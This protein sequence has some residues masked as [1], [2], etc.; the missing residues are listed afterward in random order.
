MRSWFRINFLFICSFSIILFSCERPKP[1]FNEWYQEKEGNLVVSGSSFTETA[2]FYSTDLMIDTIYRSMQGPFEIKPIAIDPNSEELLWITGYESKVL[3]A[4]SNVTLGPAF[5]CHNNLDY[6][7]AEQLPWQL[8]TSGANHRI[9]TLSQGQS[10]IQFPEGFG[11]PIPANQSLNMVSQVLNHHRPELFI[12]TKHQ[13]ELKYLRESEIDGEMKALYQQ[14][15][16][17]TKQL[18]GAEG[19]HG[20][21]LSCLPYHDHEDSPKEADVDHDCSIEYSREADYNPYQDKYGRKFTGHWVIPYGPDTLRTNVSKMMDLD[22]S[23]RIHLISVHLHPY[24]EA[25]ELWDLSSN[26]LI[27]EASFQKDS[28][29][30]GFKEIDYFSSK[31]GIPVYADHQYELV[32]AYDCTDSLNEHTAMAVMYLYLSE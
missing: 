32:S 30:F 5:M 25:L 17:V 22:D 16:F 26:Q 29:N 10:K 4:E 2:T 15:V 11:I 31:E 20:M 12:N 14:A 3:Q 24:A 19:D 21:P 9:F 8:K 1:P 13:S 7:K 28:M 18:S 6:G 27:Y 23:S